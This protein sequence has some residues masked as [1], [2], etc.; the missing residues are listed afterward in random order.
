[1]HDKLNLAIERETFK[2]SLNGAA[3]R[4][5]FNPPSPF[6]FSFVELL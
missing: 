2:P 6:P 4:L 3:E 1:M 5:H